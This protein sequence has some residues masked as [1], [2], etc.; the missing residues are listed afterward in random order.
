MGQKSISIDS[1]EYELSKGFLTSGISN[2]PPYEYAT[3]SNFQTE[4]NIE[5][6]VSSAHDTYDLQSDTDYLS[7][8]SL[9]EKSNESHS[10]K[11]GISSSFAL[12]G[13][14]K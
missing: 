14:F 2:P 5:L 1:D 11:T 8:K 6:T 4:Q 10:I 13:L 9:F 3:V 7:D 12:A